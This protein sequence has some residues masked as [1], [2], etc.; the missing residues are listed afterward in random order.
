MI[1]RR[2]VASV[3]GL[4]FVSC[5]SIGYG[6]D[7]PVGLSDEDEAA[8]VES[9]LHHEIK[10]FGTWFGNVR[11]FSSENMSATSETRIAKNGFTLISPV[12]IEQSK[13]NYIIEYLIIRSI[14][15]RSNV[16]V[17]SISSVS[18]GR[19]CFAPAFSREQNFHYE[20]QKVSNEWVGRLVKRPAPF[21]FSKSLTANP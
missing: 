5:A 9:L 8:I 17:V 12:D 15:L 10:P 20:F 14:Y 21:P 19:P 2:L 13:R 6:Q 18:E 1:Y 11:N 4:L 3:I 16:V 7:R